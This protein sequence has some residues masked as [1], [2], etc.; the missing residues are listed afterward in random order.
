VAASEALYNVT[1][2]LAHLHHVHGDRA[3]IH[4]IVGP[5]TSQVSNT[6][7]GN[8]GLGRGAA[9][10]DA[11]AANVLALDDSGLVSR[12]C[13]RPAEGHPSLARTDNDGVIVLWCGH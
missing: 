6:G 4:A 12:L 1:L 10:V 3:G 7:A 13:Q 9:L 8:H 5:A 2:A 11:A